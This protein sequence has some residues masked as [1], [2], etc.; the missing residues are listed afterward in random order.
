MHE[1]IEAICLGN[2]C[3]LFSVCV[4]KRIF[5]IKLSAQLVANDLLGSVVRRIS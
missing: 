4:E 3:L 2:K 1:L 5:L